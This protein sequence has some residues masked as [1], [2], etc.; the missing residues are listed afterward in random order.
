MLWSVLWLFSMVIRRVAPVGI[1]SG[2]DR[3]R[4]IVCALPVSGRI[5]QPRYGSAASLSMAWRAPQ[6][7]PGMSSPA[8]NSC[9]RLAAA[10]LNFTVRPRVP[11]GRTT[12]PLTS[13]MTK[14]PFCA[15]P[16]PPSG[17]DGS[18]SVSMR[19]PVTRVCTGRSMAKLPLTLFGP[20]ARMEL[21]GR[22]VSTVSPFA[23]TL[24]G[25]ATVQPFVVASFATATLKHPRLWSLLCV[26]SRVSWRL[27]PSGIVTGSANMRTM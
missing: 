4:T 24:A 7:L 13:V 17:R 6:R 2:S 9:S 18:G 23:V 19:T 26:C 16:G 11:S 12:C 27:A 3:P 20:L 15:R 5:A 21:S 14:L 1:V 22:T 10:W 25:F 8:N